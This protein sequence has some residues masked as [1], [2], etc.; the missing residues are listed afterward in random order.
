[1]EGN[2]TEKNSNQSSRSQD[3]K[4]L[5][6]T[7]ASSFSQGKMTHKG[8]WVFAT[9]TTVSIQGCSS[10]RASVPKQWDLQMQRMFTSQCPVTKQKHASV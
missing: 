3:P 2:E 5:L 7:M 1:M 8:P 4:I 6:V 10:F 9:I